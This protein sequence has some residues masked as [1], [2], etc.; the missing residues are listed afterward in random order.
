MQF[1]NVFG[2]LHFH[3]GACTTSVRDPASK[4]TMA[5]TFDD[6]FS[7]CVVYNPPHREAICIEPYTCLPD[8]FGLEQRGIDAGLQVLPP[9]DSVLTKIHIVIFAEKGDLASK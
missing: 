1:D 5:M 9:A 3:E 2:E 6:F 4:L 7:K 8:P